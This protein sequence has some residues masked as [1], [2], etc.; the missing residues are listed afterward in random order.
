MVLRLK[1]GCCFGRAICFG[2]RVQYKQIFFSKEQLSLQLVDTCHD[3]G[4]RIS[5]ASLILAS[6]VIM[7]EFLDRIR[8]IEDDLMERKSEVY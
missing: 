2:L 1:E 5:M 8:Q 7:Q 4:H 6:D 3:R